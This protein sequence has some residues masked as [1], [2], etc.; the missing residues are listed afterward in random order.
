MGYS[1][2]HELST[3]IMLSFLKKFVT[4]YTPTVPVTATSPQWPL[5]SVHKVAI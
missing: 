5:S 4:Y 3:I 1:C 2:K